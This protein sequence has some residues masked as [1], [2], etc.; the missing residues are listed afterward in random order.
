MFHINR[1]KSEIKTYDQ[2][3]VNFANYRVSHFGRNFVPGKPPD[4]G[5]PA[6]WVL[7]PYEKSEL[8]TPS[9]TIPEFLTCRHNKQKQS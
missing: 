8:R 6:S 7:Q 5:N 4:D 1:K 9:H 3:S 2:P